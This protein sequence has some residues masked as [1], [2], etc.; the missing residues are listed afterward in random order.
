MLKV[1]RENKSLEFFTLGGARGPPA[2]PLSKGFKF[3]AAVY[4]SLE[5]K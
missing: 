5:Q 3:G 2:L 4:L 1:W